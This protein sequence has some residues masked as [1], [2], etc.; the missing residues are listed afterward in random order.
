V[1]TPFY[2]TELD[3]VLNSLNERREYYL[4]KENWGKT[5][6]SGAKDV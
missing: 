2:Q 4:N 3:K 6:E 5:E 1:A